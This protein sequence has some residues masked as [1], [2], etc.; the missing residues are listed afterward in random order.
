MLSAR[1]RNYGID[2]LRMVSMF[3][4]ALLHV[5]GQGGILATASPLSINYEAAWF[6]EIAAFCAVNCYALISGYVGVNGKFKY[7]NIIVMWLQVTFYTVI[8]TVIFAVVRPEIVGVRQFIYAICPVMTMQY[9][10]FTAYFCLFFFIP[11]INKA[12]KSL[13]KNNLKYLMAVMVIVFSVVPTL[14]RRDVFYTNFGCSGLWLILLYILGAYIKEYNIVE[15]ISIKRSAILYLGCIVLTWLS[16]LFLESFS[17]NYLGKIKWGNILVDYTS[18][19]ILLSAIALLSI[20]SKI[21]LSYMAKRIIKFFTPATFGVYLIHVQP[22]V[23]QNILKDR[24]VNYVSG[25]AV[26]LVL[27]VLFNA[28]TIYFLCSLIDLVRNKIFKVLR[29]KQSIER[30]EKRLIAPSEEDESDSY[31]HSNKLSS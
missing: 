15:K 10:Y 31:Y 8:I 7:T 21:D 25:S 13:P 27:G 24:F 26:H 1:E 23:W 6:V 29:I 5:M 3:M 4:V 16:K 18:P 9:W 14:F 12:V 22:L 28:I 20:F 11:I 30:L 17:L 19:T 2:L